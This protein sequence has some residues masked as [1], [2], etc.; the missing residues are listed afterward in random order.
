M[1]ESSRKK[2][3]TTSADQQ[4]AVDHFR[5]ALEDGREWPTALLEA[6]ALWTTSQ[7]T[8]AGRQYN[9][10]VAGEAFDW[11]V[12]AERLFQS[13]EVPVPSQE[14]DD[15]LITGR[16]PPSFDTSRFKSLLGMEKYRGYL[17]YYYGVTVEEGLQLA[18]EIEVH[19]RRASKGVRYVDDYSDEAFVEIYG[20]TKGDLLKEFRTDTGSPARCS[21]SLSESKEFTYWLFKR[22]L[23]LSDKAK[24]AS[25]TRK[26]LQQLE[27]MREATRASGSRVDLSP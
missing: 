21:M 23:R 12:L 2:R 16:F 27:L 4:T 17:N 20:A 7:E 11:L 14:K 5:K 6:M 10:F 1:G 24:I 26:G 25:D 9:Y 3:S 19:K 8:H 15:L 18:T 22:R 13:V